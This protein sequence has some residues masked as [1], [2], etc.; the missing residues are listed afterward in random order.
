VNRLPQLY[1]KQPT[2]YT[3]GHLQVTVNS[4]LQNLLPLWALNILGL[5]TKFKADKWLEIYCNPPTVSQ[6]HKPNHLPPSS[7]V[8][9]L[10]KSIYL[11]FC[12]H[13]QGMDTQNLSWFQTFAL[14]WMLHAFFWVIPL[15]PEFYMPMFRNTH[16]YPSMKIEHSV[17][18]RR[19]IK[20]RRGELP[21]R[22][23]TTQTQFCFQIFEF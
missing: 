1:R 20:F 5:G 10:G 12:I 19:H 3:S 4:W 23:H 8:M 6:R 18:K 13:Q 16:T 9:K 15:A 11:P 2:L 22:K 21:R 17:P 14:F 7:I